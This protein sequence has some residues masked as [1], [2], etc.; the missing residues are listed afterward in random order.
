[1]H[2]ALGGSGTSGIVFRRTTR[3]IGDAVIAREAE[4]RALLE[5]KVA[6]V[7]AQLGSYPQT[8]L[9]V[10]L[11]IEKSSRFRPGQ[12]SPEV[13]K[14]LDAAR[15]ASRYAGLA[16]A[17]GHLGRQLRIEADQDRDHELGLSEIFSYFRPVTPERIGSPELPFDTL[18]PFDDVGVIRGDREPGLA[19]LGAVPMMRGQ[20]DLAQFLAA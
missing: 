11:L 1:M 18:D 2:M 20:M 6:Q 16:D 14:L 9:T 8:Q 5:E 17:M 15:A 7:R 13:R 4:A 3:Q 10:E 19:M 12:F